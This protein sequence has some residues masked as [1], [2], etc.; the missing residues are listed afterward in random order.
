MIVGSRGDVQPYVALALRLAKD[1]HR[2]RVASH[3]V[4]GEFVREFA[5]GPGRDTEDIKREGGKIEFFS[6]GGNPK[7]LMSYMVK[8]QLFPLF[9]AHRDANL[10]NTDPGL[11]PGMES[12]MNGD[13]TKKRHMIAEVHTFYSLRP[14]QPLKLTIHPFACRYSKAAG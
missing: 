3:E 10:L 11:V 7:D 14:S 9:S 6:I 13:I 5:E 2:V 4:F 12:I 1:G 8:S